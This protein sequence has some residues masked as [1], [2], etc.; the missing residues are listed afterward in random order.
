MLSPEQKILKSR[1]DYINE[2]EA[3]VQRLRELLKEAFEVI[4][5]PSWHWQDLRMLEQW[6][7]KVKKEL[8]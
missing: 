5:A 4:V 2:L 1:Q 8:S 7:D 6:A 3:E